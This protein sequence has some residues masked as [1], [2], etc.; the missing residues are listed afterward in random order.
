[1]THDIDFPVLAGIGSEQKVIDILLQR[2]FPRLHDTR[3]FA[4]QHRVVLL[5]A[6][7][8]VDVDVA[9][10]AT[11]FE[12]ESIRRAHSTLKPAAFCAPAQPRT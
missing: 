6:G 7:N 5:R 4:L 3:H 1:L 9:L 11:S 8:G 2:F 10:G 12:I